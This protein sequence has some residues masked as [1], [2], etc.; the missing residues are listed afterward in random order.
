MSE[1]PTS[2]ESPNELLNRLLK[3][4]NQEIIDRRA[5]TIE[6]P[7]GE[8]VGLCYLKP[9]AGYGIDELKIISTSSSDLLVNQDKISKWLQPY[10][11]PLVAKI[12]TDDQNYSTLI[13]DLGL[14]VDIANPY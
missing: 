11:T 10:N 4:F 12:R 9:I 5:I 14:I 2:P 3:K 6:N 7:N 8:T 13:E 1:T